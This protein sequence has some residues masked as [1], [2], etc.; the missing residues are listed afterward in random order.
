LIS[1]GFKDDTIYFYDLQKMLSIYE[2]GQTQ[3]LH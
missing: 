1:A 3:R 2:S